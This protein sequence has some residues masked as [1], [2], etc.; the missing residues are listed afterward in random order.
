[1]SEIDHQLFSPKTSVNGGR[2]Y[3]ERGSDYFLG[4]RRYSRLS[5][6]AVFGFAGAFRGRS[7]AVFAFSD[8]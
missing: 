2:N 5:W 4:L 3:E 7:A 1:M 8:R 6:A